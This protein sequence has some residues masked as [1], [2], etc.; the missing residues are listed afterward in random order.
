MTSWNEGYVSDIEYLP[1]FYSHQTP[2]H[3]DTVCLLRNIEPPVPEGAPF[4]YCELGCG[5][6]ETALL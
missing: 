5:V 1:G 6:G 2:A 3:I 4:R